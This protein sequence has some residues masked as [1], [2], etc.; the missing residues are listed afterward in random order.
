MSRNDG[1]N[2]PNA[3]RCKQC[4]KV[5]PGPVCEVQ[6]LPGQGDEEPRTI[7]CGTRARPY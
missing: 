1:L 4:G 5:N 3:K 6:T 2:P 7:G